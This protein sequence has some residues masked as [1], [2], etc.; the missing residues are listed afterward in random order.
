M[1]NARS[2]AARPKLARSNV[3]RSI[4]GC[5]LLALALT[6]CGKDKADPQEDSSVISSATAKAVAEARKEIHEGNITISNHG[7]GQNLPKAEITP[8][9]DLLIEGKPVTINAEQRA[10]LL[11][12]RGHVASVA[13]AGVE[14]GMQGA[15]LGRQGDGRSREGTVLGQVR[16]GN[17][18][19]RGSPDA[20]DQGQR[21]QAL[22]APAGDA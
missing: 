6:A 5:A 9:G 8:K 3:V 13:E 1:N 15:D 19:V 21:R 17:R 11:Q 7:N 22:R 12:Y 4:A 14:I 18:E 10:L 2:N 20:Q 16:E